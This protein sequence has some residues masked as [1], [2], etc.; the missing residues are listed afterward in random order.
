M[1]AKPVTIQLPGSE[2]EYDILST[3]GEAT[4]RDG[5]MTLN[6]ERLWKA[7]KSSGITKSRL[8]LVAS[9]FLIAWT[10][11]WFLMGIRFD[12][13]KTDQISFG[14]Q[15]WQMVGMAQMPGSDVFIPVYRD[16]DKILRQLKGAN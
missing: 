6:A 15:K 1:N 9:L 8:V 14:N 4:P 10:G 7:V 16:S 2:E 3:E 11:A 5:W 13:S 12:Q